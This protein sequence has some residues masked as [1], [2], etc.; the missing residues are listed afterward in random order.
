MQEENLE[1]GKKYQSHTHTRKTRQKTTPQNQN[2]HT[3]NNNN[4]LLPFA[5]FWL[6]FFFFSLKLTFILKSRFADLKVFV[7][8]PL[9]GYCQKEVWCFIVILEAMSFIASPCSEAQQQLDIC[10]EDPRIHFFWLISKSKEINDELYRTSLSGLSFWRL[11][12]K[13]SF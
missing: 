9:P 11:K 1:G 7:V 12:F 6:F 5:G 10:V 2:T 13:N 3:N 4:Y 8:E